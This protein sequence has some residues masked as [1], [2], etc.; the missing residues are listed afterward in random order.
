VVAL[1]MRDHLVGVAEPVD[2]SPSIGQALAGVPRVGGIES[3]VT[4]QP[5]VVLGLDVVAREDPA[6]VARLRELGVDVVL[7]EPTTLDEVAALVERVAAHT[8][9][10]AAGRKL[11][12]EVRAAVPA[13]L[14]PGAGPR[15]RVFVYDCC[16][17]PFTTGRKTVLDDLITRAGGRNVF[18]DLD[19]GWTH[20]SWEAVVARHPDRIVVES[21]QHEGQGDVADKKRALERIPALRGVPVTVLPLACSLGGLRSL[22]GLARLRAAIGGPS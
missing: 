4:L 7:G 16:D 22:E 12:A 20:V 13:P 5:S 15:P 14:A 21:Y 3:I 19:A 6:L 9:A 1:G 18:G 17:P 2:V 8:G 10:E 11:A